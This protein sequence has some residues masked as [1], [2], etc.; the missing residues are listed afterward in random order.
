MSAPTSAGKKAGSRFAGLLQNN[1]YVALAFFATALLTL[2][3][4]FCFQMI[5]FG[6]IPVEFTKDL[7]ALK[8]LHYLK[9]LH[10]L[11]AVSAGLME[12]IAG[13]FERIRLLFQLRIQHGRTILRMDAFHQY[14]PLFGEYYE[15][16]VSG[17]S[18]LYSW[19]SGLGGNFLGNLFNYL[20]SPTGLL[21]VLFGHNR[22]PEAVGVMI[23][24]KA[25]FASGTF[26]YMLRKMFG[27]NDAAIAAFGVLYAFCGFFIAYYWDVMW[28]DAMALLP[29][30]ALGVDYVIKKQRFLLY[31][32]S[33]AV[34]LV[35][36]YYMGFMVCI[37][38]VLF[39]LL[40]YFSFYDFAAQTREGRNKI[41]NSR[42]LKSGFTFV[43]GSVLAGALAAF[44]LVPVYFA[45]RS[46]SA[47]SSEWPAQKEWFASAFSIFDFLTNHLADVT[48][49]IRSSGEDVL[50]NIYCGVATL[51]LVPL[52]FFVPSI[53][54]REKILH[55]GLLALL[56]F[57]FNTRILN[58]V[59]HGKHFPNDL[60]YR[61]SFLYSFLLLL[62]AFRTFQF[63]KE[64]SGKQILGTG[65]GATLF[66]I[67]VQTLGSKNVTGNGRPSDEV[68]LVIYLNIAFLVVY[69]ILFFAHHRTPRTKSTALSLLLLCAVAT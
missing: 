66:V 17:R 22:V 15:R 21:V 8:G 36:N 63:L 7:Q 49:T 20:S 48:P 13:F 26:A 12:V 57:S 31:S 10:G 52:Y 1:G 47:T 35:S 62:I 34:T 32:V 18:L 60:P 53:K 40:R 43:F 6:D 55:A 14:G 4:W 65:V 27:R 2:F 19:D 67:A 9:S 29:L 54:L 64:L 38:S 46:S 5:P 30:V 58:F 39:Y 37:F 59:W 24:L 68:D 41:A 42:L 45:L 16:L 33:L 23:L 50:P 69:T 56:F 3:I 51:L 25:A 61:F 44:A 11:R 28:I